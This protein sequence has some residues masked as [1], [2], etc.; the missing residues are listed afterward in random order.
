M[1]ELITVQSQIRTWYQEQ[2]E[3]IQHQT[4][5]NEF[6]TS[7]KTRIYHH[8]LHKRHMSK[9]SILKLLTESGIIT[10]HDSCA[11]YLENMV[12]D[13]LSKPEVMDTEAQNILLAEV[14]AVVTES[15]NLMLSKSPEKGEVFQTLKEANLRAAPGTDRI[16]SLVYKLCWKLPG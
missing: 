2:S 11:E 7:E 4:R 16:T 1:T 8:E 14:K 13:L 6:Q 10:G 12:E 3:R 5:V 9:S 15:D